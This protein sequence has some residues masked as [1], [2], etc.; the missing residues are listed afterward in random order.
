MRIIRDEEVYFFK[1]LNFFELF[2]VQKT[3]ISKE[4]EK[5]KAESSG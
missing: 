1:E 4:N 3:R 2:S 5:T